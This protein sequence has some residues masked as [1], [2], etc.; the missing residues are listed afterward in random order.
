[1]IPIVQCCLCCVVLSL[2]VVTLPC[3]PTAEHAER[4]Q[5]STMSTRLTTAMIR[6]WWACMT[7]WCQRSP[8]NSR[9]IRWRADYYHLWYPQHNSMV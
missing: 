7:T 1:M 9:R 4:T 3:K 6:F 8:D 2:C 5:A